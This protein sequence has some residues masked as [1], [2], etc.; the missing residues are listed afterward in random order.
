[1]FGGLNECMQPLNVLDS[2]DVS[3]YKWE[4]IACKGKIPAPRHSH[5][6]VVVKD[7]LILIGGTKS[8]DLFDKESSF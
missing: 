2:F 3:T 4:K 1:M 7:R 8:V 6:A 5:S